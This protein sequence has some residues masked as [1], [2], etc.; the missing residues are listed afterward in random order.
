MKISFNDWTFQSL[1]DINVCFDYVGRAGEGGREE[2]TYY[3]YIQSN[4]PETQ[5]RVLCAKDKELE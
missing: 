5:K 3:Y 2:N 4:V 1:F